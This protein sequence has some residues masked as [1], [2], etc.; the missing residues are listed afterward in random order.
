MDSVKKKPKTVETPIRCTVPHPFLGDTS[1]FLGGNSGQELLAT[2]SIA[3]RG[4]NAINDR[5]EPLNRKYRSRSSLSPMARLIYEVSIPKFDPT[6]NSIF[7]RR[8]NN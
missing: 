8:V 1:I 4:P 5:K 3:S 7:E 6:P 2:F